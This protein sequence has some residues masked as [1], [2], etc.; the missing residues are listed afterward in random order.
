M[1]PFIS[2]K[3][4]KGVSI[5]SLIAGIALLFFPMENIPNNFM[6]GVILAVVGAIYLIDIK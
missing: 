4:Q 1:W 5:T 2:T 6:V 3:V